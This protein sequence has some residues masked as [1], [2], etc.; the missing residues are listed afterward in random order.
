[1]MWCADVKPLL[2][3]I[4]KKASMHSTKVKPS[5]FFLFFND[6]ATAEIYPLP[7]HD[8]FPISAVGVPGGR[9]VSRFDRR[10]RRR[11]EALEQRSEEHTSELQSRFG[12]S[13]AVFCLK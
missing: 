12:I 10:D 11:Y 4:G 1:M 7:L 5:F 3:K 13:Y 9:R 2:K 6:A 8:A